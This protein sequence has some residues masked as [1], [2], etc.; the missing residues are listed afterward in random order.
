VSEARLKVPIS[1]LRSLF[2]GHDEVE[3]FTFAISFFIFKTNE[4]IKKSICQ[5]IFYDGLRW[6]GKNCSAPSVSADN[7]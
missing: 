7:L 4:G 5:F 1:L 2:I 3:V 6:K